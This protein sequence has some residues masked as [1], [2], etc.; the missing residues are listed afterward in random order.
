HG[1][2]V[3]AASAGAGH[4]SRFTVNLPLAPREQP[5]ANAAAFSPATGVARESEAAGHVL[6]VEDAPDTLE[7]LRVTFEV[8]GFRTSACA[9]PEEA[10]SIAADEHFDII[11]SDIG[12]PNID[13][14]ELLKLLRDR[15]PHLRDIPALALTGYAAQKDVNA[16]LSAGF[17]AHLAK[18]FD[19]A[20]LAAT[21]DALLNRQQSGPPEVES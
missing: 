15:T 14:Y 6:I 2:T 5:A 17:D 19:P 21:V 13:G 20:T 3:A 4:G 1:G 9:T 8:R 18:P 16:A 10:L 12:L 7:M 11:I